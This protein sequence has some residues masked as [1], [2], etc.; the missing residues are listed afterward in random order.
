[1]GV[2]IVWACVSWP[3]NGLTL[4]VYTI[5]GSLIIL[6]YLTDLSEGLGDSTWSTEQPTDRVTGCLIKVKVSEIPQEVSLASVSTEMVGMPSYQPNIFNVMNVLVDMNEYVS[7]S[8]KPWDAN[9]HLFFFHLLAIL[10][11][12][13]LSCFLSDCSHLTVRQSRT[14]KSLFSSI[15]AQYRFF[16]FMRLTSLKTVWRPSR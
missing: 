7:N 15:H 11:E 13:L 16:D 2:V 4:I 10:S 6:L 12:A 3:C 5:W 9:N 8:S 14:I 1:M